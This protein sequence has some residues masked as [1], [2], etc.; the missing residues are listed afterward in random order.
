MNALPID[1]KAAACLPYLQKTGRVPEPANETDRRAVAAVV[2]A[3]GDRIKVA[4]DILEFDDFFTADDVLVFDDKAF[5]KRLRKPADAADLLR[6]FRERLAE[7]KTF[8]TA[9]LETE[10]KAYIEDRDIKIGQIIHALRVAVTG[11]PV[12]FGMFETLALV[13][14]ERCLAR[15]DRA[16]SLL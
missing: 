7:A 5:E 9:A 13:G 3:A 10:L 2:Q 4:G 8:D 6:G 12:G 1:E 15:I 16:L 14:R 11:K